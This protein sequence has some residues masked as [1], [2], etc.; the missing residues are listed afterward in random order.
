MKVKFI[1]IHPEKPNG[2]Y[3]SLPEK[4]SWTTMEREQWYAEKILMS[5]QHVIQE[6]IK[7]AGNELNCPETIIMIATPEFFYYTPKNILITDNI[8]LE[9]LIAGLKNYIKEIPNNII[10]HF[11]TLSIKP[12]KVIKYK[13]PPPEIEGGYQAFAVDLNLTQGM[14]LQ[15]LSKNKKQTST[16]YFFNLAVYG[17]GGA[18]GRVGFYSKKHP[19]SED[20]LLGSHTQVFI[21][22]QSNFFISN[23]QSKYGLGHQ[24]L[25]CFDTQFS[26]EQK[27]ATLRQEIVSPE[28]GFT[29]IVGQG[30]YLEKNTNFYD[31]YAMADL[32]S[33]CVS[34][35]L[36]PTII[37]IQDLWHNYNKI[38][39]YPTCAIGSLKQEI[40]K[41]FKIEE[42]PQRKPIL[43]PFQQKNIVEGNLY[44]KQIL[45]K[46]KPQKTALNK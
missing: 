9:I 3:S 38:H 21:Q 8:F 13:E 28:K 7:I 5:M 41:L 17:Q 27:T 31:L 34:E 11:G 45:A 4:E 30:A 22:Q 10:F 26:D 25:I 29:H 37:E 1:H 14:A 32:R 43:V 20:P 33:E 23:I 39:S 40:K 6:S 24:F 18:H 36:I 46:L 44:R 2:L 15:F 16:K 12:D 19:F 35:N 42:Q